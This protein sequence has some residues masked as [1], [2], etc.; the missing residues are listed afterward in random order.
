MLKLFSSLLLLACLCLPA[1]A[2]TEHPSTQRDAD[3][4]RDI[5]AELQE[6]GIEV[7]FT[8]NQVFST[9]QLL[10]LFARDCP[11]AIDLLAKD[12]TNSNMMDVGLNLIRNCFAVQGY[13]QAKIST[14]QIESTTRGHQITVPVE[15]GALYR[16]GKIEVEGARLFTPEQIGVMINLQK[17]DIANGEAIYEAFYERLADA[18]RDKGYLHYAADPEPTF[19]LELGAQEGVVDFLVNIDEGKR[20]I[21]REVQFAGNATTPDSILRSALRLREGRPFSRRLFEASVK[22]LNELN[23]FEQIDQEKDVHYALD[24]ERSQVRLTIKV[25]EKK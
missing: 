5:L 7:T 1:S 6:R 21:L 8:G 20:F 14:A 3:Q 23:L 24:E 15:E 10:D 11:E 9:H 25:K 17:G 22:N 4:Q 12:V 19:H 13:L 2:Q 16:I 18:Y